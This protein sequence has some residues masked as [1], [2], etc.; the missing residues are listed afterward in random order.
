MAG[1]LCSRND[2]G[3]TVPLDDSSATRQTWND[4]HLWPSFPPVMQEALRFATSAEARIKQATVAAPIEDSLDAPVG[5][6]TANLTG[7]NGTAYHLR[8]VSQ[9]GWLTLAWPG[10]DAPGFYEL[11]TE[12]PLLRNRWY[13]ANVDTMESDL[14]RTPL[15]ALPL[16]LRPP[17]GRPSA[18]DARSMSVA[19]QPLFRWVLAAVC[20]LILGES[21]A[22][23]RLGR[24]GQ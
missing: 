23:M 6:F 9:D 22:A 8:S 10:L 19:P 18:R 15:A 20:I 11:T 7:P 13:A 24:S 14:T 21:W 5:E 4:W 1:F 17:A 12:P 2:S 16:S 3:S